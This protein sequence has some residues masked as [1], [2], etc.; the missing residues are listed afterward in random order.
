KTPIA[1]VSVAVEAL[2]EFDALKDPVRTREYLEIS[3][4]ELQRLSLLVDKV[5]KL[6][7]FE[8]Q[9]IELRKDE[10]D[11]KVLVEDIMA[12][13]R[14]QFEKYQA[15]VR[16]MAGPNEPGIRVV[17]PGRGN[18][19]AGS[20]DAARKDGSEDAEGSSGN[21]GA[22]GRVEPRNSDA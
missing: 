6:S 8:K 2:K 12:S 17:G 13:M 7:L 21:S 15:K 10:F 22:P 9:E 1:T 4:H 14:L 16:L 20:E 5:L 18:A 11:F 3:T 19:G